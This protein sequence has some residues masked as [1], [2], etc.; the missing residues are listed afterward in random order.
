MSKKPRK[1]S[2]QQAMDTCVA[3]YNDEAFEQRFD[4]FIE[5]RLNE[6]IRYQALGFPETVTVENVV[7]FLRSEPR[8]LLRILGQLRL[9]EEKFK[10]IVTLIRKL[11]KTFDR[12]WS[13]KQ[14]QQRIVADDVFAS[15]IANLVISGHSDPLLVKHL[16]RF[17]RERLNLKHLAEPGINRYRMRI[18]LKD[19]YIGTYSNW[20]G[21]LVES[22]IK[23]KLQE[24]QKSYGISFSAG[25]T[26]LVNVTVDWAIP[27]LDDPHVIIMCS[28]QETT[29]SGQS[30]KARDMLACYQTIHQR[31]VQFLE[32]RAFVNFVDGGGWLARQKDFRRLVTGCHYFLNIASLDMLEGIVIKHV[33]PKYLQK[34]S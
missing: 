19:K 6:I 28:Y 34:V 14:I 5:D 4:E 23:G 18:Q 27:T 24:I 11:D 9:S 3:F 25:T 12:E 8:G 30:V 20:K 26:S 21:D 10:R 33:P 1:L 15:R 22:L 13:I 2:F 17:Y 29:S 7:K 31:N 32:D 16:P